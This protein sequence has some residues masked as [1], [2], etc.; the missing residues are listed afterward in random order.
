MHVTPV[1]LE[2]RLS[3]RAQAEKN[4]LQTQQQL[5]EQR[6]QL[7]PLIEQQQQTISIAQNGP[8]RSSRNR[9]QLIDTSCRY[10]TARTSQVNPIISNRMPAKEKMTASNSRWCND[11]LTWCWAVGPPTSTFVEHSNPPLVLLLG[12]HINVDEV[13]H[14][15]DNAST[16]QFQRAYT[17]LSESVI[18]S[19]E[20]V[21][22][23]AQNCPGGPFSSALPSLRTYVSVSTHCGST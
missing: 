6:Q 19:A 15:T 23:L 11:E 2:E 13:A 9:P 17:L 16:V 14:A 4:R 10:Q 1:V 21:G 12:E 20:G 3:L 8:V 22:T 5:I 18:I 7:Q